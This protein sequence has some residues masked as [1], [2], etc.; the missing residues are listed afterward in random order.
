MSLPKFIEPMLSQ[1]GEAFDSDDHLFEIKWD[2]TRGLAFI[3][4]GRCRLLNRRRVDMT[5]RYPDLEFLAGLDDGTVL[6]GEVIVMV[7]GKPD[8]QS[9]QSR[10]QAQNPRKI[11][12]LAKSTPATFVVF[13]R[14][15][16]GGRSIMPRPLE[17]R[18]ESLR[19]LVARAGRA[20]L[21]FSDGVTGAGKAFFA[22][23]CKQGLEGVVAKRLGSPYLPGKRTA[24]WIKIKRQQTYYCAVIGW[25][26]S[27]ERPFRSLILATNDGGELRSCGKV[28]TGFDAA[29]QAKLWALIESR[30]KRDKPL[31][32]CKVR[33]GRWIEPFYCRVSCMER[34]PAGELRAPVFEELCG[35]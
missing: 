26:P 16:E 11:R 28:G 31:V 8:F 6:D 19:N 32:P 10:E 9:L 17:D 2:G 20:E 21:I 29:M 23:A 30:P 22:E 4:G 25:L 5:D 34:T 3:E 27:E 35:E 24:A 12:G 18:R 13:D 1:A 33:G 15:Y 7:G 14:L